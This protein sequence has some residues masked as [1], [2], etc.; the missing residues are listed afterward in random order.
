[1]IDVS[2]I[3]VNYN[4]TKLLKECLDSVKK[5]T[6]GVNYEVIIV[7][8]DSNTEN[9]EGLKELSS[10]YMV[11]LSN[12]NLGFGRANNL[13]AT[14]AS[15]KYL[16]LLNTDTVLV[17]NA[18]KILFDYIE[19]DPECGVVGGNMLDISNNLTYSYSKFLPSIKTMIRDEILPSRFSYYRKIENFTYNKTNSPIEVGFIIGAAFMISKELFDKVGGFDKDFFMYCEE[20]ELC[21]R[22]KKAGYKM[23]NVPQAKIIHYEGASI[24]SNGAFNAKQYSLKCGRS[25]FLYFKKVYGKKYPAKYYHWRKLSIM[26]RFFKD[27]HYKEKIKILNSEF[28]KWKKSEKNA[29]I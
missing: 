5:Q 22:I 20:T 1:M 4:T 6:I 28:K 2:I 8:N 16:F 3:F 25:Q 18:I 12:E 23:I 27:K 7:D 14:Y 13:G 26:S 24:P 9:K 21:A 15:G 10:E 29:N 19:S 17:N 11:V